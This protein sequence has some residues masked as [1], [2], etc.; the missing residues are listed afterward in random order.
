M[1]ADA[2]HVPVIIV[3]NKVDLYIENERNYLDALKQ[4]Y[5][6]IGY[7]CIETSVVGMQGIEELKSV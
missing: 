2:Y 1:S 3:F 5:Q 4:L 6:H 7:R